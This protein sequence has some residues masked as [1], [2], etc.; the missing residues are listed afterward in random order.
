MLYRSLLLV[1]MLG[2]ASPALAAG[3]EGGSD[4]YWQIANF[5]LLIVVLVVLLRTPVREYFAGRRSSVKAELDAAADLL[6]QAEERHTEW[7]RKMINLDAD[8]ETIRRESRERALH[9]R[10]QILADANASA[11]RIQRDATAAVDQELRR[12]RADLQREASDLAVELAEKILREQVIDSDRDR[13]A[14]EF[15]SQLERPASETR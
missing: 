8:L 6:A 15:I 3:G 2:L 7:Q 4:F 14:D 12:A 1:A 9:E 13:L 5:V 10:D 11:E